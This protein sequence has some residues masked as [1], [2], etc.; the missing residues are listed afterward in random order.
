M[1]FEAITAEKTYRQYIVM[2]CKS[3]P[4][5][6]LSDNR[7]VMLF[8]DDNY[9]DNDPVVRYIE[10]ESDLFFDMDIGLR[11]LG[12]TYALDPS[13]SS[14]SKVAVSQNAVFLTA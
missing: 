6:L 3:T 9:G 2:F 5:E 11:Y 4:S 7:Y 10:Y 1:H 8:I 14:P 12:L 13:R